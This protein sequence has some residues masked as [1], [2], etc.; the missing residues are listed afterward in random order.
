MDIVRYGIWNIGEVEM[1]DVNFVVP[2]ALLKHIREIIAM[3]NQIDRDVQLV[4]NTAALALGAPEGAMFDLDAGVFVGGA[5]GV[6]KV[7]R[8]D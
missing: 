8:V 4:V 5:E 1:E 3:R 2:G 6:N 7:N